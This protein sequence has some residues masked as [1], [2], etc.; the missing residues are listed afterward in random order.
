MYSTVKG[1]DVKKLFYPLPPQVSLMYFCHMTKECKE[2]L[3]SRLVVIPKGARANDLSYENSLPREGRCAS[4][5]S[6]AVSR[7]DRHAVVAKAGT[8][9]D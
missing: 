5:E 1:K 7:G 3:F 6:S 2:N 8:A 4:G 9:G